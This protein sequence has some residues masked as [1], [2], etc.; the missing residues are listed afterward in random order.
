MCS[1]ATQRW[2]SAASDSPSVPAARRSRPAL[3]QASSALPAEPSASSLSDGSDSGRLLSALLL[4]Q[5][6]A[7]SE[8]AA[9]AEAL[10]ALQRRLEEEQRSSLALAV[11]LKASETRRQQVE[12][13]CAR[14]ADELTELQTEQAG[15]RDAAE[16]AAEALQ[17]LLVQAGELRLQGAER[18]R[19]C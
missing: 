19:R 8:S 9:H 4:L 1:R 10:L 2:Q 5:Q 13:I 14:L 15:W 16:G 7:Q 11:G 18:Q 17:R 6:E 3:A 12:A